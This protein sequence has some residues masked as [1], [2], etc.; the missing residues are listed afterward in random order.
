MLTTLG[1][2]WLAGGQVDWTKFYA[3]E[4]RLRLPLPTYPF[5]RQ[6]YWVEPPTKP[7]STKLST[8]KVSSKPIQPA[9]SPS[10]WPSLVE[11]SSAQASADRQKGGSSF[12]QRYEAGQASLEQL[13]LAYINLSLREL[14]AFSD[15]QAQYSTDRLFSRFNIEARYQQLVTHWLNLLVEHGQ[16]QRQT[17][18]EGTLERV[19]FSHL[20]PMSLEAINTLVAQAKQQWPEIKWVERLMNFGQNLALVLKGEKEP[21][22]LSFQQENFDTE[23]QQDDMPLIAYFNT[24]ISQCVQTVCDAMPPSANLRVLEIGAGMGL[25]TTALLPMLPPE[26][27]QYTFTDVGKFFLR[28]AQQQLGSKYP[29]MQF[30]E[31]NVERS[32]Q[33]QGFENHRFDVIVATMMLHVVKNME[34]TIQHVRSLLAPG[35]VLLFLEG[36]K[37]LL[38]FEVSDG[39]LMQTIND[40]DRN[41]GN[42]FLSKQQWYELLNANGFTEVATFP[43]TDTIGYQVFAAQADNVTIS[44]TISSTIN[45]TIGTSTKM[46]TNSEYVAPRTEAQKM[47]ADIWTKALGLASVGINDN[48]FELGG[49]SLL[50]IGLVAKLNHAFEVDLTLSQ[51]ID[52]PTV[53]RLASFVEQKQDNS[54]P[55]SDPQKASILVNLQPHGSQPPL[56]CIHPGGGA[57]FPFIKLAQYLGSDQPLYAIQSPALVGQEEF[58]CLAQRALHYIEAVKSVQSQGPYYLTG[59]SFGGNMAVEMAIQLK[60]QGDEIGFVGLFDSYPPVSY[61]TQVEDHQKF[62]MG[63][64]GI[65]QI[66]FKKQFSDISF[67]KLQH[68]SEEEQWQTIFEQI[69]APVTDDSYPLISPEMSQQLFTVW[70]SQHS[71]LK[72]HSS[73]AYSGHITLFQAI[74][75]PPEALNG[76]LKTNVDKRFIIDGWN[77]IA[78]DPIERIMVPGN[79]FTLLDEPHVQIY[80]YRTIRI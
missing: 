44:A 29:F 30:C 19:C 71:E 2:Y 21:L 17:D 70:K 58:S 12:L 16:L 56:F 10:L 73:E 64:L 68:M 34:E 79:H 32:P 6:S 23:V 14:G 74:E 9:I 66:M 48:F 49:D 27:T 75:K 52:A 72:N 80:E 54:D 3:N 35:G 67:D 51:V 47:I 53:A 76:L 20:S 33:A 38:D 26:R 36:T 24:I 18:E 63:F 22:Q 4:R 25:T 46:A 41:Q 13:S 5:E 61:Q 42:P 7:F 37:D 78:G 8:R 43:E 62:L 31:L 50:A 40:G 45:A 57:V 39:L 15:D 60:K 11:A 69:D 55:Q 1:K 28:R 59:M 65:V 77:Q